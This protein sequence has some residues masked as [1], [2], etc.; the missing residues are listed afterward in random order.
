MRGPLRAWRQKRLD[1]RVAYARM[2]DA[3]ALRIGEWW[4]EEVLDLAAEATKTWRKIAHPRRK[5]PRA[6]LADLA[7]ALSWQGGWL[8]EAGHEEQALA[9]TGEA[10]GVQ[11]RVAS[12]ETDA[13]GDATTRLALM[14]GE[15]A[16]VL[17]LVGRLAEAEAAHRE[18][19]ALLRTVDLA[20]PA[21]QVHLATSL[22]HLAQYLSGHERYEDAAPLTLES[23]GLWRSLVA[24]DLGHADGHRA[25]LS[26]MLRFGGDCLSRVGRHTQAV[27]LQHEGVTL[28]RDLAD[29][30]IGNSGA[31]LPSLAESL[32]H[33]SVSLELG[34]HVGQAIGPAREAAHIRRLLA[35]Q[36][37]EQFERD[38]AV[39]LSQLADVLTASRVSETAQTDDDNDPDDECP[40]DG[41]V[42]AADDM[43]LLNEDRVR[44]ALWV[45]EVGTVEE[46]L[47]IRSEQV[48]VLSVIADPQ[49]GDPAGYEHLLAQALYELGG[50]RFEL[51]IFNEALPNIEDGLHILRRLAD[52][53]TGN[54]EEHI[55]N[56]ARSL[57]NLS[58]ALGQLGR[59][60]EALVAGREALGIF[61]RLADAETGSPEKFQPVFAW[62]LAKVAALLFAT[63]RPDEASPVVHECLTNLRQLADPDTGDPD[64][65]VQLLVA[66]L[67]EVAEVWA[68]HDRHRPLHESDPL[69]R[70]YGRGII[71]RRQAAADPWE[72]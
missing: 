18:S 53:R 44:E 72:R 71:S 2:L 40:G 64:E 63:G 46:E 39:S 58:G 20:A 5:K 35:A 55:E 15:L 6:H 42:D 4:P 56:V 59:E 32:N 48:D 21:R 50:L 38:L 47:S 26:S 7:L 13:S 45:N 43:P 31:F 37:P 51:G 69:Q 36:D 16:E 10:V 30:I 28:L 34:D 3:A 67:I 66:T 33:L 65:Y 9:V 17:E 27:E 49:T 25:E 68:Q 12:S 57:Y 1:G 23:L 62:S 61:R 54:P 8:S 14:V 19:I 41:G 60:E 11:R 22:Y 52:P 24:S 29:P 70:G